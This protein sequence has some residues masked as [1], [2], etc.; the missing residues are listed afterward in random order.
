MAVLGQAVPQGPC[1]C[2]CCTR[3]LRP[4]PCHGNAAC[5]SAGP[6]TGDEGGIARHQHLLVELALGLL[7]RALRKGPLAGRSPA[8]LARLDPLL[9]LL[10]RALRCR[11]A[12]VA[13]AALRA[14][15]L[16][17]PLP[18]PGEALSCAQPKP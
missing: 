15:A 8:V 11:A 1:S 18:L 3:T 5:S 10:V 4:R 17:V 9:P 12:A 16:L 2:G 14:L 13:Q 6:A 7:L